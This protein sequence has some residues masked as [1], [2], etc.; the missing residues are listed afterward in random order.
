[1]KAR[2][3][4]LLKDS[5]RIVFDVKGLVHPFGRV[6]AFPRFIPDV[7]GDRIQEGTGYRKIYNM[8][9]RFKFLQEN[10]P[11]YVVHDA[12]FD[13]DLCEI[14]IENVAQHLQPNRRLTELRTS[15]K[16]DK[17]ESDALEFLELLKE[18]AKVPWGKMGIS[19]SL[20][21]RLHT[22]QSDIDPVIYGIRN[23]RKVHAALNSLI[24]ESKSL[25]RAYAVKDLQKLF[26]FRVK[27]ARMLFD[28]FKKTETRKILQG[29]FKNRD[30]FIRFIKDWNETVTEYSAIHYK[31]L[32]YAKIKAIVDDDSEGIFTPCTYRIRD[33]KTLEGASFP[34]EEISSF[35]GRFCDQARTGE[36]VAAQGKVEHVID[37]VQNREYCRLLLG[38]KPSDYMVLG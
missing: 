33:V 38:N 23:C 26:R 30:Y 13:E 34:I 36:A 15:K 9:E 12:M 24:Q 20:L 7:R 29:K 21:A 2:E 8:S 31:K 25:A 35:R 5:N 18:H 10:I 32:G 19:G 27:D 14:P 22:L 1:M 4:D 6:I 11:G 3:G 37:N 28:D 17:I 16:T